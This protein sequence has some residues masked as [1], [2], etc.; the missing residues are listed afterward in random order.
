MDIKAELTKA[1]RIHFL[2][3]LPYAQNSLELSLLFAETYPELF[4]EGVG[5]GHDA[6]RKTL[7]VEFPYYGRTPGDEFERKIFDAL[8]S[9]VET[10]YRAGQAWSPWNPILLL[11]ETRSDNVVLTVQTIYS[12]ITRKTR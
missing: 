7:P 10:V 1:Y 5:K 8:L 6:R 12:P 3:N 9:E 2:L 11:S 4:E